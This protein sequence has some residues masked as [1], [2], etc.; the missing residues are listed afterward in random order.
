MT[1]EKAYKLVEGLDHSE[2][3]SDF[4]G[5]LLIMRK[6]NKDFGDGSDNNTIDVALAFGDTIFLDYFKE[7]MT[8]EDIV[9]LS[10]YGFL[11]HVEYE[12]WWH[13]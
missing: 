11:L 12:R 10:K 1:I 2:C 3:K 8:E 9:Q 6:Y 5:G 7:E 4:I 13:Y